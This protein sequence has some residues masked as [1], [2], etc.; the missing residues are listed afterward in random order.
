MESLLK[1]QLFIDIFFL[2]FLSV[3]QV[4]CR[5][6]AVLRWDEMIVKGTAVH[7]YFFLSFWDAG[8]MQTSSSSGM[9]WLLKAQLFMDFFFSFCDADQQQ[10]W[11]ETIV[12]GTAVHG[13]FFFLF[14]DAGLMQT[15]SSSGMR[16]SGTCGTSRRT[17][18]SRASRTMASP[19]WNV[20]P[21]WTSWWAALLSWLLGL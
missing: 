14:C 18:I 19:T 5:P 20:C 6:A 21:T 12:K 1:A 7:G 10:F 15:S 9:R 11:D 2:F 8:L 17:R 4:W 13:Y 3:T 16:P